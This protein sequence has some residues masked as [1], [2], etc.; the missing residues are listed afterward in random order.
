VLKLDPHLAIDERAVSI[1][2][3]Q[4]LPPIRDDIFAPECVPASV[5]AVSKYRGPQDRER[6]I[7]AL[8]VGPGGQRITEPKTK[9]QAALLDWEKRDGISAKPIPGLS[10]G[11]SQGIVTAKKVLAAGVPIITDVPLSPGVVAS[12]G[13]GV[14]PS[15][16]DVYRMRCGRHCVVLVGF[17]DELKDVVD[18]LSG[19]PIAGAFRL[20]NNW[21][22][23][24][25]EDGYGWLPYSLV[26]TGLLRDT[27]CVLR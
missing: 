12:F 16:T 17:S 2:L 19:R 26:R 9:L 14:F 7:A 8:E 15:D 10:R 25:G 24:W 27:W 20:R 1:S 21:G 4:F 13:E 22:K 23:R 6:A 11:A 5:E 3:S 18:P